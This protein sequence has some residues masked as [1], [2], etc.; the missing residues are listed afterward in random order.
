M[1]SGME[2]STGVLHATF[3]INACV[4]KKPSSS[5]VQLPFFGSSP[6][7]P[8]ARIKPSGLLRTRIS[9]SRGIRGMLRSPLYIGILLCLLQVYRES[10]RMIPHVI[11]TPDYSLLGTKS[12][13]TPPKRG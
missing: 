2:A 6:T 10:R 7:F 5:R 12:N 4:A 8:L 13:L 9:D 1:E 11:R 3:R